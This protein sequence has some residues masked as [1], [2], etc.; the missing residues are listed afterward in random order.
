MKVLV[1]GGAGFIGSHIVQRLVDDGHTVRVLEHTAGS[2]AGLPSQEAVQG[3]M[4]DAA[5]LRRCPVLAHGR[6][7][8]TRARSAGP[9]L[10]GDLGLHPAGP[11]AL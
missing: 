11:T 8:G 1:T 3:S 5:S 2:A 10:F 6:P 9:T 7:P 4:G